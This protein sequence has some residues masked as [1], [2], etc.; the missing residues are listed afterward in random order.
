[1][2]DACYS[3]TWAITLNILSCPRSIHLITR[4]DQF[5]ETLS[6][7]RRNSNRQRRGYFANFFAAGIYN[8]YG[9]QFPRSQDVMQDVSV[10]ETVFPPEN[11]E[12]ARLR[13]I[14][15]ARQ[16]TLAVFVQEIVRLNRL[17]APKAG[18]MCVTFAI[19]FVVWVG[20]VNSVPTFR[21]PSLIS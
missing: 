16:T 1:M 8:E 14:I 2:I 11:V 15:Q 21:I 12:N 4:S 20:V 3:G 10:M 18:G 7:A 6:F 5:K 9:I 17:S 13:P 19:L